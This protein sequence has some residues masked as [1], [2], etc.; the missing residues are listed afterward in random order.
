[1][2]KMKRLAALFL[3]VVMIMAMGMTAM[4]APST[5]STGTITVDNATKGEKYKAF[6]IFDAVPSADGKHVAYTATE[7]MKNFWEG[8]QDNPFDFNKNLNGSWNVTQKEDVKDATLIAALQ[9]LYA[10][11]VDGEVV[12]NADFAGI[13][14]EGITGTATTTTDGTSTTVTFS[15]VPYGYYLITSSLGATVTVDSMTPNANVIDKNQSGPSWDG[16]GKTIEGVNDS[17]ETVASPM[18][19]NYGDTIKFKISINTTNY[20]G[21]EAITEYNISDILGDGM[22]YVTKDD[23]KDIKVSVVSED[24]T[25][26]TNGTKP[27]TMG[28]D[29]TVKTEKPANMKTGEDGF[30]INVPWATA[31]TVDEVTTVTTKYPSP[32]KLV[33]EYSAIVDA[34]AIPAA[35]IKNTA[36][37]TYKL[38]GESD[39]K[40]PQEETQSTSTYTYALAINKVKEDATGLADAKF[41][42]TKG[43]DTILVQATEEEGVYNYVGIATTEQVTAKSE[44]TETNAGIIVKSPEKG[45]I[46]VKGINA[47]KYT[48]T[49]TEAP[50]GY[51]QLTTAEE[52]ETSL[53]GTYTKT[54]TIYYKTDAEG[55]KTITNEVTDEIAKEVEVAYDV[56]AKTV[57]NTT[58]A[59]L[60]STGGI[61]TT[62]F[63]VVGGILVVGAGVLLITKKRMS[64]RD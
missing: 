28:A 54:I 26:G 32:A 12:L 38:V 64:A 55:N 20:E 27:L 37:F 16:N 62:I 23:I 58:G 22:S 10:K 53:T 48:I 39:E 60:P 14:G 45:L 61:G 9:T 47:G 5:E 50:A 52:V 46:V 25:F 29:Y 34:D 7:A 24:T 35:E 21:A 3:A 41:M 13:V 8:R 57:V 30:I 2:K 56:V 51:N 18:S 31:T 43:N 59:V 1:M 49:E 11:N 44:A 33:V 6:K 42:I 4:A 63:Y 17:T 36:G 15:N 19:A 40:K